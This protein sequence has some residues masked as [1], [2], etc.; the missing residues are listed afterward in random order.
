MFDG[1][2]GGGGGRV[3]AERNAFAMYHTPRDVGA[4]CVE[5]WDAVKYNA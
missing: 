1:W 4:M 2:G 5:Q 3:S